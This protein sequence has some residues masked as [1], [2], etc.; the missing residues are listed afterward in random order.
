MSRENAGRPPIATNLRSSGSVIRPGI[1]AMTPRDA[2]F[3]TS[4]AVPLREAAGEVSADLVIP[5][6]PGI[7]VI[8]PGDVIEPHKLE[9]LAHGV[10]AGFYISAA[11][12]PTLA[13]IRVVGK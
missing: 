13:T 6:P 7:P 8:A 3:A 1:Q 12:D 10:A 5:Y 2:Y 4:R 11:A 9:Y